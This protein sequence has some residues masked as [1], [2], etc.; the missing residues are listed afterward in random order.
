[1]GCKEQF[2]GFKRGSVL[3]AGSLCPLFEKATSEIIENMCLCH[4][5][6]CDNLLQARVLYI[7]LCLRAKHSHFVSLPLSQFVQVDSEF[8]INSSLAVIVETDW[9]IQ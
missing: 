2:I 1:M 3:C 5:E 7:V 8:S 9:N 4:V 6:S